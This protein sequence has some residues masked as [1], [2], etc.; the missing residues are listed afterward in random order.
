MGRGC[1]VGA[2]D[3]EAGLVRECFA[4][5]PAVGWEEG[6][7][8]RVLCVLGYI[9][10]EERA[11]DG[12]CYPPRCRL[13]SRRLEGWSSE[14]ESGLESR[15]GPVCHYDLTRHELAG[16]QVS[17]PTPPSVNRPQL[18]PGSHHLRGFRF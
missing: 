15:G 9:D 16:L 8:G 6:A 11:R 17:H 3:E 10:L 7:L 1:G 14:I 4:R 12:E 2:E 5:M 18:N 13:S